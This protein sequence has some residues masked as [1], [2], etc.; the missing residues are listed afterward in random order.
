MP[1]RDESWVEFKPANL[2]QK[3]ALALN[4]EWLRSVSRDDVIAHFDSGSDDERSKTFASSL[5][6]IVGSAMNRR[7]LHRLALEVL[8][9]LERR[10]Q[11]TPRPP[12]V[13]LLAAA[14]ARLGMQSN[15]E[16]QVEVDL[17][18]SSQPLRQFDPR[19]V[20]ALELQCGERV[21]FSLPEKAKSG[22]RW[23]LE[24]Q[25]GPVGLVDM[26]VAG[27]ELARTTQFTIQA[28][29]P[30]EATLVFFTWTT[31]GGGAVEQE[32]RV[33]ITVKALA[34]AA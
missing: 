33:Q 15:Q 7:E 13:S 18:R 1:P 5:V 23:Y 6:E 16:R 31:A 29:S 19:A 24:S 14:V 27:P 10:N 28:L 26:L 20:P 11:E 30:G 9:E 3:D 21:V 2:L 32:L 25:S 22:A 34:A 4:V 8:L 17:P 12:D